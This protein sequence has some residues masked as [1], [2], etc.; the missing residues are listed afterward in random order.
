M[1]RTLS[2]LLILTLIVS[3]S[4]S[5][6]TTGSKNQIIPLSSGNQ[7]VYLD[8]IITETEEY[9][10][11]DTVEITGNRMSHDTTWWTFSRPFNPLID[12]LEF[13]IHDGK[14]YS[15]QHTESPHGISEIISLEYV[16]A[17]TIG[18]LTYSSLF[19]GDAL[20]ERTVKKWNNMVTT[21][22]GIF[23][24]SYRYTYEIYP[25]R[26]TEIICPKYGMISL[27]MEKIYDSGDQ[28]L[29]RKLTL[30]NYQLN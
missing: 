28:I 7:W 3:C 25:Y 24:P 16:A 9:A 6:E 8:S 1:M 10:F 21:P 27:E 18:S 12:A 19:A 14:I 22:A 2:F 30:L 11:R 26:M 23:Y 17:P 29:R 4:D 15:L 5:D 13:M 20:Y